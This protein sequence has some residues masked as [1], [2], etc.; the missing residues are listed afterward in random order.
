MLKQ[1]KQTKPSENIYTISKLTQPFISTLKLFQLNT[2][3]S[4]DSQLQQNSNT[5]VPLEQ[6]GADNASDDNPQR[7]KS[8]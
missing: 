3:L 7:E 5:F 8:K 4:E 1:N 2:H 6:T